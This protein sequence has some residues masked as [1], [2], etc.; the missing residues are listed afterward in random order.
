MVYDCVALFEA[1]LNCVALFEA[2]LEHASAQQA[3]RRIPKGGLPC[4]KGWCVMSAEQR[5]HVAWATTAGMH[6]ALSTAAEPGRFAQCTLSM[7][8]AEFVWA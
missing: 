1:E 8:G 5:G 7:L 4:S 2:E 3:M 6:G